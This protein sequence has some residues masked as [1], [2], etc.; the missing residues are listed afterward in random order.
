MLDALEVLPVE[1]MDRV[2]KE[3]LAEDGVR[4]LFG[5]YVNSPETPLEPTA[6]GRAAHS[7]PTETER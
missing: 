3:A 7:G 4:K 1:H 2:L 6:G 5:G